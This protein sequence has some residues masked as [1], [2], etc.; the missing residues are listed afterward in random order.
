VTEAFK[1]MLKNPGQRILVNIF[2]GIMRATRLRR[3]VAAAKSEA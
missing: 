1:L 2:G 3:R